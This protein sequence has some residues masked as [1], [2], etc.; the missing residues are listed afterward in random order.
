MGR[1]MQDDDFDGQLSRTLWAGTRGCADTG[2]A[3]AVADRIASGDMTSWHDEWSRAAGA[4]LDDAR[5]AQQAGDPVSARIGYLSA[6]EYYRQAYFYTRDDLDNPVLRDG[7][8]AHRD[9]FRRAMPL[10]GH[11]ARAVSIPYEHTTLRGYLFRPDG[12]GTNRP[13][14]IAP[15]GYDSTAESGYSTSAVPALWRGM[16]CLSF[17]GP[18][19]GGVLYEQRLHLRHDYEAVLTPTVDWLIRQPGV[20]ARSLVLLGRS[21]AGYLAPRGATAEH[22]IAALVCDPVHYDFTP[23]L[24]A[25]FGDA[26]W[27]RIE[28]DDTTLDAE[29]APL[30]DDPRTRSM[31]LSRMVTHG[32]PTLR[33]YAREL[34]RFSLVGLAERISCPTM[35]TTAEGDRTGGGQLDEFAAA[36]TCPHVTRTFTAE[37]GAGG[38]CEGLGQERFDRTVYGWLASIDIPVGSARSAVTERAASAVG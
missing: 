34:A 31:L 2:E 16:N 23:G 32:T 36:L 3:L 33:E 25:R 20:D 38:H 19:Q 5:A 12:S 14:V 35:A 13:T 11:D 9:A 27:S 22:R 18:G 6:S 4:V 26:V 10:L 1:F 21:F 37:Q 30:F 15:A 17:E 8:R 7:F 28:A 24:R 29:F